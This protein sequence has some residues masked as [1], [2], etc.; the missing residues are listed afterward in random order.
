MSDNGMVSIH[1]NRNRGKTLG[2]L[3]AMV[4]VFG[5]LISGC[6][7]RTDRHQDMSTSS[8]DSSYTLTDEDANT[9]TE[10]TASDLSEQSTEASK[11]TDTSE[12]TDYDD[13]ITTSSL[14]PS[15]EATGTDAQ[16]PTVSPSDTVPAMTTAETN[17]WTETPVSKT[18]YADKNINVRSG[19]GTQY[20][21][22]RSAASG[23]ALTVVAETTNG[24]YVLSDGSYV[25]KTV[26][27]DTLPT[28]T[29]TA[30]SSSAITSSTTPAATSSAPAITGSYNSDY[31][32][33]VVALVNAQRETEG[34][35]ALSY[36]STLGGY[37]DIRA[38]EISLVFSHTRPDGREWS[39]VGS[40]VS[41]ENIAGGYSSPESVMAGWMDSSGHRANILKSDYTRIGVSCYSV[42]GTLYWVQLFGY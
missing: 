39:T 15:S 21:V 35:S 38:F 26:T 36:D 34:L 32:S 37:S 14:P 25:S 11:T 19:P 5:L 13:A 23:D 40:G 28:P 10:M 20:A 30:P 18:V 1:G 4:L 6:S 24:W 8:V 12:S 3:A 22:V 7:L 9:S 2:K 41:G 16:A 29:S 27:S 17:S 31:A 42:G 33:Q